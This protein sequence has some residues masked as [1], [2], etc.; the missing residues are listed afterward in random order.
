MPAVA[1]TLDPLFFFADR[2][3]MTQTGVTDITGVVTFVVDNRGNFTITAARD[4]FVP[5]TVVHRY[6]YMRWIARSLVQFFQ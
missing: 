5:I 3:G 6:E 4:G 2:T 1:K